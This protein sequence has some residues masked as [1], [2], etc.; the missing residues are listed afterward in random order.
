M[1]ETLCSTNLLQS[2]T[3]GGNYVAWPS[4]R[5]YPQGL[6]QQAD[7]V[8]LDGIRESGNP[9][10]RSALPLVSA[11]FFPLTA[12]AWSP[13]VLRAAMGA[14]F[15]LAIHDDGPDCVLVSGSI[16]GDRIEGAGLALLNTLESGCL[17]FW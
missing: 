14:H 12:H 15:A 1:L 17:G 2:R 6:D 11:Q 3:P 13:K 16:G 9:I 4:S 5:R 10:L 7:A 8:L